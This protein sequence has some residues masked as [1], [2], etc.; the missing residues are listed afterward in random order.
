M[1][2]MDNSVNTSMISFHDAVFA[3][4]STDKLADVYKNKK[5]QCIDLNMTNT[6]D[7]YYFIHYFTYKEM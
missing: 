6:T 1:N 5:T 3:V 4:N 2:N 7:D